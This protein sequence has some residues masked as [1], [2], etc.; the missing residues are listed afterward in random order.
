MGNF[1]KQHAEDAGKGK[2][3]DKS[4]GKGDDKSGGKGKKAKWFT[5]D[6]GFIH[7]VITT[8]GAALAAYGVWYFFMGGNGK[9]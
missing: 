7:G 5:F 9:K 8:I 1:E 6:A 4:G 3:D 2:G